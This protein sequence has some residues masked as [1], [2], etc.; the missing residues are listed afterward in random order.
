M[1]IL[2][3]AHVVC[4]VNGEA[5]GIVVGASWQV[6]YNRKTIFAVD[7][8]TAYEIAPATVQINGSLRIVRM[9]LDGGTEGYGITAFPQDIAKEQY[10]TIALVDA[11]SDSVIF[12]ADQCSIVSQAWEI[13]PKNVVQGTLTFTATNW[14]S[15]AA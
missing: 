6:Q 9:I 3:G 10:V 15:E 14:S 7:S 1:N 2:T 8:P 13:M 4:Y 12:N 11:K 5:F